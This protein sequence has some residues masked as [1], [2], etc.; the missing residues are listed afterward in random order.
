MEHVMTPDR[1]ALMA[2]FGMHG[3]FD[4]DDFMSL[5]PIDFKQTYSVSTDIDT[6]I[7]LSSILIKKLISIQAWYAQIIQEFRGDP[8]HLFLSLTPESLTIW[9]RIESHQRFET[10]SPAMPIPPASLPPM[11]PS[12]VP[13]SSTFRHSIK[14]N[15][16]DY[17]KLK[18]ETQWRAFDR[19][20]RSTAASH[21]TLDILTPNYVPPALAVAT[22]RDKQWFMYNVFINIIHTTK[23]KNCVPEESTSLDAQ[24]VYDH[25]STKLS[26]SKLCQELSL[27]K[28]DD[29]WRKS[30]EAFLH[31][32]TSGF[33]GY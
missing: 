16:S 30:F 22:F 6:P 3:V 4:I 29:K 18:D 8:I 17:P 10:R 15:I 20:L 32:W 5:H 28:L 13:P 25:L 24:K 33:R 26:A 27:L 2:F 12:P 19:Q 31:F 1:L 23:G 21:D 9:R 14:I 7:H 11:I